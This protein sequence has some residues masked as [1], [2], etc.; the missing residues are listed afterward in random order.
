M[1]VYN[2]VQPRNGKGKILSSYRDLVAWKKAIELVTEIYRVTAE[3]PKDKLYGL[4][5]QLRRASVSIPSNIA[6]GQGHYSNADFRRYLRHAR[7]SLAEVETQII[8]AQNLSYIST[9]EAKL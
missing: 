1:H 8:I 6:E 4:T 7:G 5:N 9:D 2:L 3:F